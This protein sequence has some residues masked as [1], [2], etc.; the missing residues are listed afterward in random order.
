MH[1]YTFETLNDSLHCKY[2]AT[3]TGIDNNIFNKNNDRQLLVGEFN[4][5]GKTDFILSPSKNAST[6]EKSKWLKILS[7]GDGTWD[8]SHYSYLFDYDNKAQYFLQ[9]MN[10]D[11]ISDIVRNSLRNNNTYIGV[12]LLD[13][14]IT[15]TESSN[16]SFYELEYTGGLYFIPSDT[17]N[18]NFSNNILAIRNS[19]I[20]RYYLNNSKYDHRLLTGIISSNGLIHKYSYRRLSDTENDAYYQQEY[21]AE[22]PYFNYRGLLTVCDRSITMLN[23]QALSD[24]SYKY[25]NAVGH[26]QGLGL[27]GF[28]KFESYD[29]IR[30]ETDKIHFSD[31]CHFRLPI[32]TSS[33]RD[34]KDYTYNVSISPNKTAK[35]EL[36]EMV[37][38]D[39]MYDSEDTVRYSYD[40]YGNIVSESHRYYYDHSEH[41]NNSTYWYKTICSYKN[42]I[43]DSI[44]ILGLP[45]TAT[46]TTNN[47]GMNK[48][49]KRISYTYNAYGQALTKTYANMPNSSASDISRAAPPSTPSSYN[50]SKE[51]YSYNSNHL[52]TKKSLK[53]YTSTNTFDEI[54]TYYNNGALNTKTDSLG[55]TERYVYDEFGRLK[56]VHDYRNN[57]TIYTYDNWGRK[58]KT[59]YPEMAAFPS[60]VK[61]EY[62]NASDNVSEALTKVTKTD[63][64]EYVE[65]YNALGQKIKT[66][67]E[68]F[69]TNPLYIDYNYDIYG[70]II[71]ESYPYK[72]GD[73]IKW[74]SF[75]YDQFDRL[76]KIQYANGKIEE[77]MYDGYI[78]ERNVD[79]ICTITDYNPLG[80]VIR[81]E[82]YDL[83]TWQNIGSLHY[84]YYSKN[85]PYLIISENGSPIY[86]S[87]D[88]YGRCSTVEH[89]SV[90][91]KTYTYNDIGEI[92]NIKES[93]GLETNLSYDRYGRIINKSSTY[94][95]EVSYTYNNFSDLIKKT[96]DNNR[97]IVFTY[98]NHGRII[99]EK[100]TGYNGTSLSIGYT[101]DNATGNILSEIDSVDGNET[102]CKN[103]IYDASDK[104]LRQIKVGNNIIW[105]LNKENSLGNVTEELTGP[106]KRTY[107]YDIDGNPITFKINRKDNTT[108]D[109][110]YVMNFAY[111]IS[112]LT[113]NLMSRTDATRNITEQFAYDNHNRLISFDNKEVEYDNI[114][115]ITY[116]EG[117]GTYE[118]QSSNPYAVTAL[119]LTG[120]NIPNNV[121]HITYHA[122]GRVASI[123]EGNLYGTFNY[124]GEGKRVRMTITNGAETIL[125]RQY[126]TSGIY[127]KDITPT[128]VKERLYLNGDPY[129][130]TSVMTRSN[131]GA[132]DIQYICR[133]NLGSITHITDSAG[134]I[135]QE[136]SY[137]AWGNLRNPSTHSLYSTSNQPT[138]LL[139]RGFTG[140]EHLSSFGLINMN[141][142]MYDPVIARFLSPDPYIQEKM[143]MQNY[144]RYSYC[145]NNPLKYTDKS[146]EVF[147]FGTFLRELFVNT[148][149][150]PWN[151]GLNAWTDSDNW[152]ATKNS[153]KLMNGWYAG[154][155]KQI[156]SR[157][158]WELPQTMIGYALANTYN[159]LGLVKNVDQCYGATV[160]TVYQNNIIFGG[161]ITFGSY[162]TGGKQLKADP[163]N[164]L[165]M[166][167]YGHYLQSQDSG[168]TY[169]LNFGIPSA[170]GNE[171]HKKKK[172]EQDATARGIKFFY[173]E[174]SNRWNYTR[175]PVKNLTCEDDVIKSYNYYDWYET[176]IPFKFW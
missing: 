93:N 133:D 43:N 37:K 100:E 137:D 62:I 7:K 51:I 9:D 107:L 4:G 158:T 168:P 2:I 56:E 96:Y 47:G 103:Y 146:G 25:V 3:Y 126:L 105:Q 119:N 18:K 120:N 36:T 55:L 90:G 104:F 142:R 171:M 63:K 45:L 66:K 173:K 121:Q 115:N 116:L 165:F 109:S 144:N 94:T 29:A 38:Y 13:D 76:T 44:Y 101:Y 140:H 57:V 132:W 131:N 95:G 155:L 52:L 69:D 136:L 54:Y 77:T 112:P 5:D 27:L 33:K 58:N 152:H 74:K 8:N 172:V 17:Q 68:C 83:E 159:N 72:I 35:I 71:Q 114:G 34:I 147:I 26:K 108:G 41:P 6:T 170:F 113:K 169:L 15:Q 40:A 75:Q 164:N 82:N 166:H 22:F 160:T 167:E 134:N 79:G 174:R 111:N 12:W 149:I 122:Q 80:E 91:K 14:N 59:T 81:V 67:E 65:Y 39:K 98:D 49:V 138:P 89:T 1:I 24:K 11:G 60:T 64:Y 48:D 151:E 61:I 23:N 145:L 88:N 127:E 118:Y 150:R 141:A 148:I 130:A 156:I 106:L 85:K 10:N 110:V 175:F 46:T 30:N 78:E 153:L 70:R 128:S 16:N 42:I 50:I 161:A 125:D 84:S 31:T 19:S 154:N 86:F 102:I 99:N 28:E 53:K 124:T 163:N 139:G 87:Y 21:N 92:E 129:T 162:I 117:V 176:L 73:T 20:K 135:L 32:Y 157:F 123:Q 143:N 97:Y